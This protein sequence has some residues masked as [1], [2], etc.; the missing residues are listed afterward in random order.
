MSTSWA[1]TGYDRV[2]IA[3]EMDD[4]CPNG[5]DA[6]MLLASCGNPECRADSSGK[7]GGEMPK[8]TSLAVDAV[9]VALGA[10]G[11]NSSGAAQ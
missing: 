1:A 3:F 2:N 11:L 4:L 6:Q 10:N 5:P 7:Q 9:A 8:L